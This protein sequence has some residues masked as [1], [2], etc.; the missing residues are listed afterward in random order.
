M[1]KLVKTYY[2]FCCIKCG[3]NWKKVPAIGYWR[4][5]KEW[6]C[7]DCI[8]KRLKEIYGDWEKDETIKI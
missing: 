6:T 8:K 1:R 7:G 4:T 3:K 5:I 2:H